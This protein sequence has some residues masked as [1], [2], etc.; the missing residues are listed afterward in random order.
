MTDPKY[1][2]LR[3]DR[4]TGYLK[5]RLE[6]ERVKAVSQARG[7]EE[8][9]EYMKAREV[10]EFVKETAEQMTTSLLRSLAASLFVHPAMVEITG[11]RESAVLQVENR[12]KAA[13]YRVIRRTERSEKGER[14]L[15]LVNPPA[16]SVE[17]GKLRDSKLE[18]LI[19]AAPNVEMVEEPPTPGDLESVSQVAVPTEAAEEI[20]EKNRELEALRKQVADLTEELKSADAAA[21][22]ISKYQISTPAEGFRAAGWGWLKR[23]IDDLA[24]ESEQG[25]K[26]AEKWKPTGGTNYD[27]F[28]NGTT[29]G[30]RLHV[31]RPPW[32]EI[33]GTR[34]YR[35]DHSNVLK[36][37]E[38]RNR[39]GYVVSA[40]SAR[41]DSTTFEATVELW[42]AGESDTVAV[43]P[44]DGLDDHVMFDQF[45]V[46]KLR[47]WWKSAW[48]SPEGMGVDEATGKVFLKSGYRF[49]PPVIGKLTAVPVPPP[50][51]P[52]W[53]EC[54]GVRRYVRWYFAGSPDGFWIAFRNQN[55]ECH[56]VS[57]V[58]NHPAA[59]ALR[60]YL[61]SQNLKVD[62][63]GR[64]S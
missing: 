57:S 14:Q 5:H 48:G 64:W 12:F 59:A 49:G 61:E 16:P 37:N 6:Q 11:V 39:Q 4:D 42:Q 20:L 10:E 60:E 41:A 62:E 31:E 2:K 32:F 63:Q 44:F 22:Y 51:D 34:Y 23:A 28:L 21:L 50:R 47:A 15:L 13:G 24:R 27:P 35:E 19:A 1:Q 29:F 52:W 43:N 18:E 17:V 3:L 33:A 8:L 36:A 38:F 26:L 45:F 53:E 9:L 55:H 25:R 30:E 7:Y 40:A 54:K 58:E 46:E 56:I